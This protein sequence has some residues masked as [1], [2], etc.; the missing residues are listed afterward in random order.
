[1]L[2]GSNLKESKISFTGKTSD[3]FKSPVEAAQ[4]LC[5]IWSYPNEKRKLL[6]IVAMDFTYSTLQHYFQC[7]L[8]TTTTAR[9]HCILFGRGGSP[10]IGSNLHANVLV[11]KYLRNCQ[12]FCTVMMCHGHHH[13][14]VFWL[15]ARRQQ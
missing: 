9:V 1:M 8:K 15:R 7:L 10:Q 2:I 11:R 14:A 5:R 12:V 13:A 6:S 3:T 4:D